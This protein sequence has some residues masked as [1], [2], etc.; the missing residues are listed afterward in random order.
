G[1][2]A[3]AEALALLKPMLED[4]SILKIGHHLKYDLEIFLRYGVEAV[5]IDDTLLMTY[6]L[7]GAR[8]N[9]MGELAD[10]WLGHAGI[11]IKELIGTGK[12]QRTFAEVPVEDA[13]K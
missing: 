12:K 10:H 1:Q 3:T 6:V 11:P 9:T 2:L 8:F 5:A 4:R 7:D 13:A